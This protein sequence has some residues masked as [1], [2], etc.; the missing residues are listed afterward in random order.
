MIRVLS[1]ASPK[2]RV[3]KAS[4]TWCQSRASSRHETA[5]ILGGVR[6]AGERLMAGKTEASGGGRA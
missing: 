5:G 4:V 6:R 3:L 1:L 2:D